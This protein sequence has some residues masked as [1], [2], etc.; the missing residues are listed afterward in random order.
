MTA[1]IADSSIRHVGRPYS[2]A[3]SSFI[4]PSPCKDASRTRQRSMKLCT[5]NRG[6]EVRR[7]AARA[8]DIGLHASGNAAYRTKKCLAECSLSAVSRYSQC[9]LLY[10]PS[11]IITFRQ[12]PCISMSWP[13]SLIY[14]TCHVLIIRCRSAVVCC[15]CQP[16]HHL[17]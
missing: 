4:R 5:C 11:H 17:P 15:S 13:S 12:K 16:F 14:H 1:S 9:S 3:E 8:A 6:A 10:T 2:S 7:N